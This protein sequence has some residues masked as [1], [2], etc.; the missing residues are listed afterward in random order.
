MDLAKP[1]NIDSMS[2]ALDSANG[3]RSVPAPSLA[4]FRRSTASIACPET[5][6]SA[7]ISRH[8]DV[9]NIGGVFSPEDR[10]SHYIY[11]LSLKFQK[12]KNKYC[13]RFPILTNNIV[14]MFLVDGLRNTTGIRTRAAIYDLPRSGLRYENDE[15][16]RS[17]GRFCNVVGRTKVKVS[18]IVRASTAHV[19]RN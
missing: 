6:W 18:R 11:Q 5:D 19:A 9:Q 3:F 12:C 15:S 8:A 7:N 13:I 16:G 1:A 14:A 4:W 2:R 17:V 10:I